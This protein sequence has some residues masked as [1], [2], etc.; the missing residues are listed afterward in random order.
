MKLG[1]F[2]KIPIG[3]ACW[4]S[5]DNKRIIGVKID[6]HSITIVGNW[7]GDIHFSY[8]ANVYSIIEVPKDWEEIEPHDLMTE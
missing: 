5:L 7:E 1:T 4:F 6:E 2:D 8:L 3:T